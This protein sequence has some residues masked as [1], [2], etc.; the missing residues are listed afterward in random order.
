MLTPKIRRDGTCYVCKAPRPFNPQR[1]VPPEE[2]LGDPFC[3]SACAKKFYG[4]SEPAL[5]TGGKKLGYTS[6]V[7]SEETP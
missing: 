2:Y 3:S 7:K 5:R 6:R 4:T 1:G